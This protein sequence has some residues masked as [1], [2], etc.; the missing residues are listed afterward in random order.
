MRHYSSN[1][2]SLNPEA[3]TR[4]RAELFSPSHVAWFGNS[5]LSF[6]LLCGFI[7]VYFYH[8]LKQILKKTWHSPKPTVSAREKEKKQALFHSNPLKCF[9][10]VGKITGQSNR[11]KES[12]SKKS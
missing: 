5:S 2:N 1:L 9:V 8:F 12:S 11:E 10:E 7:G 6:F 3:K 4:S